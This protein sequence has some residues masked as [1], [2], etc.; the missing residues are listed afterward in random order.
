MNLLST[1][2][3]RFSADREGAKRS[4]QVV[5]QLPIPPDLFACEVFIPT[6]RSMLERFQMNGQTLDEHEAVAG[7]LL[8]TY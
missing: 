1:G 6:G 3:F 2:G 8:L 4:G 5:H 7:R